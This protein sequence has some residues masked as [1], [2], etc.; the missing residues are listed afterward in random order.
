MIAE[1]LILIWHSD[2]LCLGGPGVGS[3]SSTVT[4]PVRT[5]TFAGLEHWQ[6]LYLLNSLGCPQLLWIGSGICFFLELKNTQKSWHNLGNL[7]GISEGLRLML[8]AASLRLQNPLVTELLEAQSPLN[9]S[10]PTTFTSC[11]TVWWDPSR[12]HQRAGFQVKCIK[13]PNNHLES[14]CH[15]LTQQILGL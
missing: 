4:C 1:V 12:G 11:C 13:Q 14:S 7:Q 15:D 3:G 9:S 5:P 6:R 10:A 8:L 2:F